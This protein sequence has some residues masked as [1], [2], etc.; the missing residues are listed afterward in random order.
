LM[1]KGT[2]AGVVFLLSVVFF[3]LAGIFWTGWTWARRSRLSSF[4]E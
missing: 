4:H 2:K 1:S 3:V